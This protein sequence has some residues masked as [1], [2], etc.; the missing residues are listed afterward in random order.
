MD[1]IKS[2]IEIIISV[3][4]LLVII[5][6]LYP[7]LMGGV[8]SSGGL[9]GGPAV[10]FVG[11]PEISY[12]LA[13]SDGTGAYKYNIIFS[14]EVEYTGKMEEFGSPIG[15]I[16]VLP[17]ID[18]KGKSEKAGVSGEVG[19]VSNNILFKITEA[20]RKFSGAFSA[21]ISS[22]I[23]PLR[24]VKDQATGEPTNT[25]DGWMEKS[26]SFILTSEQGHNLTIM[27]SEVKKYT[28]GL[29]LIKYIPGQSET[30]CEAS[31][32]ISCG[33]SASLRLRGM[34][35]CGNDKNDCER[36]LNMCNGAVHIRAD[37]V[38]CTNKKINIFIEFTGGMDYDVGDD[39][40]IS[41]WVGG[42]EGN[43]NGCVE[44]HPT[45]DSLL[46]SCL[47]RDFLGRTVFK[48]MI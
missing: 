1:I 16:E 38:D 37:E 41:F 22:S 33:E 21:V 4:V 44:D 12:S 34:N 43:P 11:E 31:I 29:P 24:I 27:I 13:P 9:G 45:Y 46:A 25:Y 5:N 39:I 36:Y 42:R 47:E 7:E 32:S 14:G 3:V 48:K 30:R 6:F 40:G 26:D 28:Y 17:V 15:L 20:D 19:K 23:P 35:D 10:K 18:L 8:L 2:L